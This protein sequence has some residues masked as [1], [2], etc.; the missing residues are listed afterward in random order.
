MPMFDG[1]VTFAGHDAAA[2]QPDL[3]ELQLHCKALS[4]LE[5]IWRLAVDSADQG[6][7]DYNTD[8]ERRFTS[9]GWKR[10]RGYAPDEQPYQNFE[11]WFDNVHPDDQ[12]SVKGKVVRHN[13]GAEREW[14]FAYRERHRNGHWVWIL[15]RGRSVTW[16]ETGKPTRLLGT[17]IDITKY[18]DAEIARANERAQIHQSHV[19]ELVA[20]RE[21][22]EKALQ[23]AE[24][25]A[26]VDHLSGLPNRRKF[27]EAFNAIVA[28]QG[29]A[30]AVMI[31]D[32]DH[33]KQINDLHG[34]AAGDHVIVEVAKR[35]GAV[36]PT[37]AI[38]ARL[39]GDEFGVIVRCA[40]GSCESDAG[41]WA[42]GAVRAM[43]QPVMW[44]G[45]R[46]S[47]S[48]SVGVAM[49]G[50]RSMSSGQLM[51]CADLALYKAKTESRGG[52]RMYCEVVHQESQVLDAMELELKHA[53][54][55]GLIEPHFQP[56]FDIGE[57]RIV[58]VEVLARWNSAALGEIPPEVFLPQAERLGLI[59]PLTRLVLGKACAVAKSWA[60]DIKLA[61]N[62][63]VSEV[64]NLSTPLHIASILGDSEFPPQ[65]L[66]LEIPEAALVGNVFV[67][68]Q[69]VAA[70]RSMGLEII[71]GDFGKDHSGLPFLRDIAIDG[72]KFDK[73][74]AQTI[75]SSSA[76]KLILKNM[77]QLANDLG[78]RSIATGV[79]SAESR[80]EL[81]N[82]GITIAQGR[83][84]AWPMAGDDICAL[85][86]H[87]C[88]GGREARNSA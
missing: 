76:S 42:D 61:A 55:G 75:H 45:C 63:S 51:K 79:E 11:Q 85:I 4:Y 56:M 20:V 68:R 72:I 3:A 21:E 22:T 54:A 88:R 69:V 8:G 15:S 30:F 65:R 32:L 71:V 80:V 48:A 13:S 36:N 39:G 17:D 12:K 86:E 41:A 43:L 37:D 26:N 59:E 2:A 81:A 52:W 49:V 24:Y 62:L 34:H 16:D 66:M 18:R 33:F 29:Q 53:I 84:F 27:I 31:I 10:I 35:L 57:G 7:W 82:I 38:V 67:V 9:D 58:A 14:E 60:S 25:L 83:H 23:K 64:S 77:R 78:L 5:S 28:E 87:I 74:Y 19:Q 46:L 6:S 40:A 1:D 47:V 73:S 44:S 50:T 70:L